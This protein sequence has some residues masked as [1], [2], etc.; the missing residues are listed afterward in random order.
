MVKTNSWDTRL[1][2]AAK[3]GSFII[4]LAGIA[5]AIRHDAPEF[6]IVS[7]LGLLTLSSLLTYGAVVRRQQDALDRWNG[8]S[9]LADRWLAEFPDAVDALHYVRQAATVG[10][11]DISVHRERMRK[12]RNDDR[13]IDEALAILYAGEPLDGDALVAHYAPRTMS[14][15]E[16]DALARDWTREWDMPLPGRGVAYKF[17][18]AECGDAS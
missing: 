14:P 3:V 16:L 5:S 9:W 8:E 2:A 4:M 6:M 12:R 17:L 13:A 18:S 11:I 15:A 10:G 7:L 1:I